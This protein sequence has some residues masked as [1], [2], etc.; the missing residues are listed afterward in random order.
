MHN[1]IICTILVP[2]SFELLGLVIYYI[3][4]IYMY[5]CMYVLFPSR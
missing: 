2:R 1:I 3:Y 5:V 4:C